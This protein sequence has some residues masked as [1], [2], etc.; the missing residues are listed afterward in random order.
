M[1]Q[2]ETIKANL[3]AQVQL[4]L[5]EY[6]QRAKIEALRACPKTKRVFNQGSGLGSLGNGGSYDE[7]IKPEDVVAGAEIIYQ[8]LIKDF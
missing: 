5:T 4:A 3:D 7:N 6:K 2:E 1:T 8:W